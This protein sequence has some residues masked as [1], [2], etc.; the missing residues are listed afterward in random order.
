MYFFQIEGDREYLN[1]A[2]VLKR[3][4]IRK[5]KNMNKSSEYD[6]KFI[7]YMLSIVFGDDTLKNNE[8]L[9]PEKLDFIQSMHSNILL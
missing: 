5:L 2:V 1:S 3:E 6:S 4:Q 9:D 8:S 7:R